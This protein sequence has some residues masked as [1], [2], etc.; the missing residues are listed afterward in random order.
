MKVNINNYIE[1][2]ETLLNIDKLRI[3]YTTSYGLELLLKLY[4]QNRLETNM[5]ID[6]LYSCLKSGLPR[7]EAFGKYINRLEGSG[8]V[9]KI[10]HDQKKS[11]KSIKLSEHI[12]TEL[13]KVFK[14]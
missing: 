10:T 12:I 11:M 5:Y 9:K 13:D 7:R 6:E 4:N 8:C 14:R 3:F 1:C 2:F